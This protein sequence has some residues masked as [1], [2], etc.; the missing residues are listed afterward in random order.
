MF[1]PQLVLKRGHCHFSALTH[2][3][4]EK[5]NNYEE[6][7]PIQSVLWCSV[8]LKNVFQEIIFTDRSRFRID[9]QVREFIFDRTDKFIEFLK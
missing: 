9:D 3:L 5:L 7:G 1:N 6:I 4:P 8:E 2:G